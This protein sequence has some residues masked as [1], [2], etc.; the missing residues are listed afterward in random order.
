MKSNIWILFCV[1]TCHD[2]RAHFV[3]PSL[4]EKKMFFLMS[5]FFDGLRPIFVSHKD[6]FYS[7][8]IWLHTGDT[9][10]LFTVLRVNSECC[11]FRLHWFCT[12][13]LPFR[14]NSP[15]S[16]S[17]KSCLIRWMLLVFFC[18]I[19]WLKSVT[20]TGAASLKSNFMLLSPCTILWLR[21]WSNISAVRLIYIA[22]A[23]IWNASS[24]ILLM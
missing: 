2:H 16:K 17:L 13:L 15:W 20:F 12:F 6:S 1:A 9:C 23:S 4:T 8:H 5:F 19:L 7:Y 24:L 21:Y 14:T 22:T 11:N 10:F 18:Q 3:F